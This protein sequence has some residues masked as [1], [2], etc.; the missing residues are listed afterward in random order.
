[1][2]E[3]VTP[4]VME[5]SDDMELKKLMGSHFQDQTLEPTA[6][7]KGEKKPEQIQTRTD[8]KTY[9]KAMNATWT[10]VKAESTEIQRLASCAKQT[11]LYGGISALLFWWQ[12]AGLLASEAAWPS[13]IVLALLAGLRI[14]S[15]MAPKG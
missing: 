4:S 5:D 15:C 11:A 10:P 12:Q 13:F 8:K 2:N 14:G 9:Q 7:P 1:M 3:N 6:T